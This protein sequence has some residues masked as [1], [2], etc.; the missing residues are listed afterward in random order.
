[1]FCNWVPFKDIILNALDLVSFILVTPELANRFLSDEVT[2]IVMTIAGVLM[3]A[4]VS[5]GIL[6]GVAITIAYYVDLIFPFGLDAY[7]SWFWL[8]TL[9]AG[10]LFGGTVIVAALN[11]ILMQV[12]KLRRYS[13]V[14]GACIFFGSRVLG[15]D[16]AYC[17]LASRHL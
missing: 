17:E 12:P 6:S 4:V 11:A 7:R 13:L 5:V 2:E 3:A 16:L 14:C 9:A 15:I 8:P 10:G 1:M